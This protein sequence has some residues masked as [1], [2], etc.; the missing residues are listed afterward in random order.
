MRALFTA[1]GTRQHLF[2][3]V[4]LAWA[5]RAAGHE[6]RIA[7]APS[8]LDE[9]V[10]TGLPAVSVGRAVDLAETAGKKHLEKLVAQGR[11]PLEWPMHPGRLNPQQRALLEA[12]GRNLANAAEAVVDDLIA[13]AQDWRPDMVV[14]DMAALAGPVAAAV[15][16]VPNVRHLTGTPSC[17][18]LELRGLWSEPL[19]EYARLFERFHVEGRAKPT[20]SVDP[21]PPSMRLP[22]APASLQVRYIPYNG[23]GSVPGWP[24]GSRRRPRVCI[25]WGLAMFGAIGPRALDP[26]REAIEAISELG[27]EIVV[28]A[29]A[30]HLNALGGLPA[31]ATVVESVPLQLVLPHCD[32]IVHQAGAGTTLTAAALGV[33]QLAI[34][35]GPEPAMQANRLAATGA[36]I[37]LLYQEVLVDPARKQMLRDAVDK[38]LHDPA[39]R[40]AAGRVREEIGQQP[41]PA[42]LVPALEELTDSIAFSRR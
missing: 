23:A 36:G 22:G 3:I 27:V 9:I 39:Q 21:C 8:I 30:E 15:L 17:H 35:I 29:T 10:H 19:P 42:A 41:S 33:P 11:W 5:C 28:V 2:P 13:F 38:L 25:T 1:L 32:A 14:H 26:Y 16:G 24:R 31:T 7:G 40:D 20:T 18:H 12:T 4:P 34:T 37:H 6:V